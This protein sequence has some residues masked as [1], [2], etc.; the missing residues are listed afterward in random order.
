MAGHGIRLSNSNGI[1]KQ[2]LERCNIPTVLTWS[3]IDV[4]DDNHKNYYGRTGVHG[5]RYSNKILQQCDLLL[6]FGSRLSLLQTGYDRN[7]FAK[8]AFIIHI[9]IDQTQT[10]KFNDKNINVD[11]KQVITKMLQRGVKTNDIKQWIDRCNLL[12][13]NYPIIQKYHIQQNFCN[14]YDFVDRLSK[15]TPKD[16]TIVTDMGAGLL[17]GF[18]SFRIKQGQKMFTSLGLGQ[19][20]HGLPAA[21]GAAMSG[22]RVLC[23]NCDGGMM[24]NLQQ[25]QTIISNNLPV[26][27]IVFNNDGYLMIKHTQRLL[28]SGRKTCVDQSTGLILPDYKKIAKAFGYK[29]YRQNQIELLLQ[30][31]SPAILQVFMNPN[32]QYIPKVKGLKDESGKIISGQLQNMYPS[33]YVAVQHQKQITEE[34][35]NYV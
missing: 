24:I 23:L 32:Q 14:S 5:F 27:I 7:K 29:Y 31:E 11:I 22:N 26:K 2:L 17:S 30:D 21:I 19:M 9:D 10:N 1:F 20:G 25:L 3:A 35:R 33:Q 13:H 12:K 18:Y 4:L 15:L 6:V 28:F 8:N 34:Q 16:Y